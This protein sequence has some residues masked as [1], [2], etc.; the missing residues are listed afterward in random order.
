MVSRLLAGLLF[1]AHLAASAGEIVRVPKP[2][3]EGDHR[4]D[5]AL[6]LLQLALSK[7]GTDYRLQPAETAMN[8]ERQVLEIEA[9]RSIDVGPIPSSASARRACCRS[10]SRSTRA[11]SAGA[12]A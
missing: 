9:G 11:C 7:V 10:T 12:W 6:Q 4:Y 8:Q 1:A 2:E 5:Y 3:F